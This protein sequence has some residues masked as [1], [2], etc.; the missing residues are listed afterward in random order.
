VQGRLSADRPVP[1]DAIILLEIIA[2]AQEMPDLYPGLSRR[3][4][5]SLGL[6]HGPGDLSQREGFA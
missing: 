3:R 1:K 2:A 5:A 6:G 4:P